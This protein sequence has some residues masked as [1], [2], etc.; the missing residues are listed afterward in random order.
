MGTF[1]YT[2]G[3]LAVVAGVPVVADPAGILEFAGTEVTGGMEI[4]ALAP[5]CAATCNA[6]VKERKNESINRQA[7][8]VA[9]LSLR[10]KTSV[11]S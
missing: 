7:I 3:A 11:R 6:H 9:I 5:A 10:Q 1:K 2:S 4:E 8:G